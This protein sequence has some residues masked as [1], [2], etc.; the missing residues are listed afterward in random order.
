MRAILA[1]S[2]V[3]PFLGLKREGSNRIFIE[4]GQILRRSELVEVVRFARLVGIIAVGDV[5]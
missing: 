3:C 1:G 5:T 2:A 4:T